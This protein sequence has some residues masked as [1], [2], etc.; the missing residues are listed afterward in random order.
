MRSF[1]LR[2]AA[3]LAAASLGWTTAAPALADA[4]AD[5][6]AAALHFDTR[7]VSVYGSPYPIAGKLDITITPAG[8]LRG[9]YHNAYQKAFIQVVG[10]RDGNY[11]WFD[12]GPATIDLGLPQE[13]PD[14]RIHFVGTMNKDGSLQG[15]IFPNYTSGQNSLSPAPSPTEN[16]QYLLTA[17]PVAPGPNTT[18]P[19]GP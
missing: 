19:N 12:I 14:G 10:G 7:I 18:N 11:V 17:Q 6:N 4:Q 1:A 8:I 15:Q 13:Q 16:D 3:W 2:C 9:Y 5:A